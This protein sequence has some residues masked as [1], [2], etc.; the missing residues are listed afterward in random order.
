M[1]HA[2]TGIGVSVG[3]TKTAGVTSVSSPQAETCRIC[4]TLSPSR[5]VDAHRVRTRN[6]LSCCGKPT[7]WRRAVWGYTGE[8]S[9]ASRIHRTLAGV[10]VISM[11]FGPFRRA[12][13]GRVASC[14]GPLT[15]RLIVSG[16]DGCPAPAECASPDATRPD[17]ESAM[18]L[19][20]C[21]D[22]SRSATPNACASSSH[23]GWRG[24][25][26]ARVNWIPCRGWQRSPEPVMDRVDTWRAAVKRTSN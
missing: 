15:A 8:R 5:T 1:L 19:R 10:A 13:A 12:V 6:R 22:Y 3:A 17:T 7:S 21:R 25:G 24:S 4:P 26:G 9:D 11:K 23:I 14:A 18:C 2:S 20:L 16:R